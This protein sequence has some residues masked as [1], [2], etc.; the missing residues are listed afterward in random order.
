MYYNFSRD[1]QP[2]RDFF[3]K[4]QDRIL[5]GTDIGAKALLSTPQEG[6][7]PVESA[8]RIRVV[9]SLLENEGEYRLDVGD[10]FLF[11]RFAGPYHGLGL[12]VEVLRK[13]YAGNFERLAGPRPKALNPPAVLAECERLEVMIPMMGAAQPGV[14]MDLS[15]V[16]QVKACFE[17]L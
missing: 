16:Q 15:V 4:Y 13:I 8:L 7:E 2:A 6:I 9:R 12:P 10:G 3:L 17:S 5:F 1:P 14:P 11:G